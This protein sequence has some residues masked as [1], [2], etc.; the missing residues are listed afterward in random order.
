[1]IVSFS[2]GCS[3][4]SRRIGERIES[5]GS[6]LTGVPVGVD[7]VNLKIL[8]GSG[9]ITG[10]TVENPDGYVAEN[11]FQMDLLR[12][13]LGVISLL[14]WFKPVV[15]DELVIDSPVVNLEMKEQGG[16]N[17]KDISVNIEKNLNQTDTESKELESA[18]EKSHDESR[19]IAIKKLVINGVSFSV[20][21]NDGTSRSGTLPTIELIDVGGSEG[22]TPGGLNAVVVVAMAREMLKEALARRFFKK[23]EELSSQGLDV[24]WRTFDAD[25]VLGALEEKLQLY[26]E[27]KAKLQAVLETAFLDLNEAMGERIAGGFLDLDSLSNQLKIISEAVQDQLEDALNS[28][29]MGELKEYFANLDKEAVEEI[30][31]AFVDK[32]SNYLGL[33]PEQI[34]RFRLIFWEE[35]EKRSE[36]LSR[37]TR[38]PDLS[39]K[40][41]VND[42]D[43]LQKEIL[44]KLEGTL[45]AEQIKSLAKRQEELRKLILSVFSSEG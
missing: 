22:K 31:R 16:S 30:K 24:D 21:R 35:I 39:V 11:A 43:A 34:D 27:Q 15:L 26:S 4:L 45:D 32:L 14:L 12:L 9:E 41:F 18:S 19:R 5:G 29:Q 28:E 7:R 37:F 2:T 33:A 36:L 20:R 42:W 23:V 25:K 6:E 1:M 13:N 44:R 10:L 40:N 8:R 3:G 38:E 17:L